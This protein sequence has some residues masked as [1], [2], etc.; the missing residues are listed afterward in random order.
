MDQ[1]HPSIETGLEKEERLPGFHMYAV[2]LEGSSVGGERE[3]VDTGV[4][5]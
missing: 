2:K 4:V 5:K 1:I 3:S